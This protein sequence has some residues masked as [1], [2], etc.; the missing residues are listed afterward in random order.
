[1]LRVLDAFVADAKTMKLIARWLNQGAHVRSLLSTPRGISQGAILSP[2]FCNLYL[3]RFDGALD[4]ANIPFVRFADDFLLFAPAREA[5]SKA[6][7][8]AGSEL[9]RLDLV[10]H[11]TK[12]SVVRSSSKVVFLGET[13]PNPSR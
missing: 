7:D 1:M 10:L 5:A 12:T 13:L 6:C 3:H 8:F 4:K 2:L 11:P 9:E